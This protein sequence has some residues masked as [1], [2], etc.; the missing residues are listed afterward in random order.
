ML[1][2]CTIKL[3]AQLF[4]HQLLQVKHDLTVFVTW[5]CTVSACMST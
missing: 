2:D 3:T 4:S 1:C 5:Q